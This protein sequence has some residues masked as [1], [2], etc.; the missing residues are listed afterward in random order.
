MKA[1]VTFGSIVKDRRRRL[2]LTQAELARRANCAAITV[3]KIESDS[4]RPSVQIA[5]HLAEALDIPSSEQA[6]FVRL[7]RAEPEPLPIP[8]PQPVLEEIGRED[9]SG[10]AIKGFELG[11]RIAVG[12]FGAVYRAVQP[13]VAREVAVKIILPQYADHPEFI[14]RF[15]AEAHPGSPAGTSPHCAAVRLLARTNRGLP[16]DAPDARRQPARQTQRRPAAA[17]RRR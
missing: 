17:G 5:Q 13:Q 15:E 7:A 12:G 4:M 14:R 9:L 3:R 2:G 6:G 11:E 16:G 8:A 1:D 10:R